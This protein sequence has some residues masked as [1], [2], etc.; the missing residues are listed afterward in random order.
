[1]KAKAT[2]IYNKDTNEIIHSV[3]I[4]Q[5]KGLPYNTLVTSNGKDLYIAES[6]ES[7]LSE[8]KRL[9]NLFSKNQ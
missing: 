9:N 3:V 8:A 1:M 2:L 6:R 5:A 7:A 4:Q